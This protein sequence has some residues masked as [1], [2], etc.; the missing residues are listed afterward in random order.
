MVPDRDP[1]KKRDQHLEDSDLI[2]LSLPEIRHL[3]VR[4]IFS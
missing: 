3:L 2:A 1:V 4:L